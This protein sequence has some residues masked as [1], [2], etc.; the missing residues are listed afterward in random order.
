MCFTYAMNIIRKEERMSV[1]KPQNNKEVMQN[2]V[3]K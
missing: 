1:K 3:V 2:F